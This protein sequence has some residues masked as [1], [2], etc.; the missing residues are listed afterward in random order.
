VSTRPDV[1]TIGESMVTF[2]W[3]GPLVLGAPL[4]ARLAG[5][6]S[7]VAIGLARLGHDVRWAGRVGQDVFGDLVLRELQAEGVGTGAARRD[8]DA[9]TG[10]MFTETRTADVVRVEYRR[11]GSAGSRLD[12]ADVE[13]ALEQPPKILHL[14]GI[15]PALS[16]S[17]ATAVG[18]AAEIASAAGVLVSLDVNYRSRLWST[19]Q[20]IAALRPLVRH[21][22]LL[23]ASEDELGLL[24]DGDEEDAVAELL[25]R[26]VTRVVVKRGADGATLW[27]P[28]GRSDVSALAVTAVDVVGAGDAFSAGLVSGLLDGLG[29]DAALARANTLGAVAVSTHGDWEGLPRRRELD[30]LA[31]A[32]TGSTHR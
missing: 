3:P 17:A 12:T 15:T 11:A 13:A 25:G 6:E 29:D 24:A 5:A 4:V 19:A 30:Q 9:P 18:R 21:T 1:V 31:G 16:G 7:N 26:G 32:S 23:I 14:T 8:P 22:Q 10:L 20:A 27:G 2:R 28:A